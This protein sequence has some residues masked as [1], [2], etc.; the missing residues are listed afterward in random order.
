VQA[1]SAVPIRAAACGERRHHCVGKIAS[2]P[3]TEK[4]II[5]TVE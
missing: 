1:L 5:E 3:P 4:A 2:L